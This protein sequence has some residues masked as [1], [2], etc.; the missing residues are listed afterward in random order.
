GTH[1]I[2]L[3]A[4]AADAASNA[5][6][7]SRASFTAYFKQTSVGPATSVIGT[8]AS[9]STDPLGLSTIL[10]GSPETTSTSEPS[11]PASS[12]TPSGDSSATT[13]DEPSSFG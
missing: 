3:G 10:S 5:C 8:T 12:T 2:L 9:T 6:P 11:S 13:R 7:A 4:P 1:C